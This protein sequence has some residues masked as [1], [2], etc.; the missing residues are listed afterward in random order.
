[1]YHEDCDVVGVCVPTLLAVDTGTFLLRTRSGEE[2]SLR[3]GT[4]I[5]CWGEETGKRGGLVLVGYRRGCGAMRGDEGEP[6]V[7]ED[8]GDVEAD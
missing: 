1:M 3:K 5:G 4:K 7:I 8:V 6:D 2:V